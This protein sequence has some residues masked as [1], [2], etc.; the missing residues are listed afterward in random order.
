MVK[1]VAVLL[2]VEASQSTPIFIVLVSFVCRFCPPLQQ[3]SFSLLLLLNAGQDDEKSHPPNGSQLH[4]KEPSP[5]SN[6]G[7]R[8]IIAFVGGI[9][10]TGTYFAL[11]VTYMATPEQD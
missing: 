11:L 2:W 1:S 10:L 9:D 8:R 7:S 4:T 5:Q 3:N 6:I